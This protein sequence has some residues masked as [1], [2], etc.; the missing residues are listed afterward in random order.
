MLTI[1][2]RQML[3]AFFKAYIVCL[4]SMLSLYVVV[5]LF[6]N[7][8][9]F[10]GKNKPWQKVAIDIAAFYG[11]RL[12]QIFDRLCEAIVLLAAMFTIAWTQ[13]NS[14]L[15]PLLSCGV[16]IHRVVSPVLAG[17]FALLGLAV[18]NQEVVVPLIS[19]KLM[20]EKDDPHAVNIVQVRSGYEPNGIHFEGDKADRTS[21]AVSNLRVTVPE[22]LAG[23]LIH[24]TAKTA[25]F[26]PDPEGGR[27][28]KWE[29]LQTIPKE[30]EGWDRETQLIEAVDT[31]R[32]LLHVREV[33]F[34]AITRNPNWFGFAST[35]RLFQEM[36]RPDASRAPSLAVL[37]HSRLVRP[38]I[39]VV[40]VM[41]GLSVILRDQNRNIFIS[42]GICLVLCCLFFGAGYSA[43]M[44]GDN[45]F[46]HPALAAW[47]PVMVFG[48]YALVL[49]DAAHT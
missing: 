47:M 21:R 13:R 7:L 29:L 49:F 12:S 24:I 17:A 43:K 26:N 48:P 11:Y 4:V 22:S 20:S 28:G 6:T 44:L 36:Q 45:D 42:A 37:F 23:N 1:I 33:G 38:L 14:E 46:V 30:I 39:G 8:D 19:D 35:I 18:F 27:G 16:S 25:V 3:A 10:T 32:Y 40:L 41:L 34:D 31:G 15:V 5:D 2:D 9:D